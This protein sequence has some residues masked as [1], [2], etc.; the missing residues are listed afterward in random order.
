MT[1][2]IPEHVQ[3][4]PPV[5]GFDQQTYSAAS[6]QQSTEA[7]LTVEPMELSVE[8]T[9]SYSDGTTEF[10]VTL[11]PEL[12]PF[13]NAALHVVGQPFVEAITGLTKNRIRR[14]R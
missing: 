1:I 4:P 10:D 3:Y 13:H 2:T 9:V 14:L 5:N 12:R 8:A 11:V 7:T 6:T